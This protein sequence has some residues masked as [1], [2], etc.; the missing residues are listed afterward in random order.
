MSANKEAVATLI[1]T[2]TAVYEEAEEGGYIA[3]AAELRGTTTQGETLGE[4]RENLRDA[5]ELVLEGNR[6]IAL[7]KATGR[8]RICET[9]TVGDK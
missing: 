1:N 8:K 4:A 5:I 7:Q 6:E 2:F 3:Y 9:V